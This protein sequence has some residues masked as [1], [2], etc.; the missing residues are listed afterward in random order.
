MKAAILYFESINDREKEELATQCEVLEQFYGDLVEFL[1][2][3]PVGAKLPECA[4]V[5]VFPQLVGAAFGEK[6]SLQKITLPVI[7]LTSEFGTVEMWDW[8]IVTFLRDAGLTVFSPYNVEL[9]KCI[10]RAIDCKKH[11]ENGMRFLMFQDDPGEG[12]QAG[13]FKRFYWWEKE[14]TQQMETAFGLKMIYRSY[15]DLCERAGSIDD[16]LAKTLSN[17]WDVPMENVSE[18]DYLK[19]VKIYI[20]VKEVISEVGGLDSIKGVGANC[21]NESFHSDTTPCLAWNMLYEK[22]NLLWACEG[23]TLT[24]VSKYI[25]YSI[26]RKPIMMTNIYPFLMGMAALKHE[27]IDSFPN[28]PNGDNHALCVHCGYFGLAPQSFCTH[29]MLRP[30]VLGIVDDNAIMVD[31]RMAEGPVTLA[32]LH[33][34]M[35]Q[36]TL[37]ECEIVNYIQYP[38]SDC[39]NGALLHYVNN[40]GHVIMD[41]LSSH[42]ALLIQG[43]QIPELVQSLRVFGFKVNQ[44]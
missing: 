37:I 17:N 38:G 2:P 5:V 39:R 13:I 12:M 14:C 4:D 44:L 28:I 36:V 22:D 26:L 40:N 18:A 9:A 25:F 7:V 8:E 27:K 30:K 41:A 35:K 16:E 31:C 21:L 29:W 32:K 1:P 34:D 43:N 19:A 33:S 23:D 10:F 3:S 24:L 6:K 15:K 11:M 42:H 20:A